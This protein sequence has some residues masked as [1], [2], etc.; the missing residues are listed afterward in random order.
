MHLRAGDPAAATP[1]IAAAR[2]AFDRL[3][4]TGWTRRLDA[5]TASCSGLADR[6][7]AGG[8]SVDRGRDRSATSSRPPAASMSATSDAGAGH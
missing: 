7:A 2:P 4:M 8:G 6:G 1:Y 3:G 5:V